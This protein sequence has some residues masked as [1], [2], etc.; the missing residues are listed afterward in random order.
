MNINSLCLLEISAKQNL[1]LFFY[2]CFM[3]AINNSTIFMTYFK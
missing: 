2:H 1:Y 3:L